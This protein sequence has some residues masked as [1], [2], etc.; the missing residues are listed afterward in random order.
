MPA[1]Q[2]S[3]PRY[4]APPVSVLGD[5]VVVE[6]G[7]EPHAWLQATIDEMRG[8][9]RLRQGWDSYAACPISPYVVVRALRLL[10]DSLP[11]K[12]PAPQVV[13]MADGG[14]Q[15]EWHRRGLNIEVTVPPSGPVEVW[16]EDVASGDERETTLDR[17]PD[18]L[19]NVLGDLTRRS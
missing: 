18:I 7:H 9:L 10:L 6:V 2:P 3:L 8:L 4:G 14:L 15:L 16:Y 19:S 5:D 12:G 13:P 17:V 1:F 11:D